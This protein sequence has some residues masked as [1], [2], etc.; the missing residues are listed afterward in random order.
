MIVNDK[1]AIVTGASSGIGEATAKALA[2]HGVKVVLASRSKEKLDNLSSQLKDSYVI[3]TDMMNEDEIKDM[4]KKAVDR[5]GRVDIL[6][7]NAGRGYDSLVENIEAPSYLELFKLNLLAPL[8][9]MQA[10]IPIMRR[11]SGGT[12]VNIS[13]GTSMMDIPNISAYSSLKRALNGLSLTAREELKKDKIVVSLVYPYMTET[14]FGK[15]VIGKPRDDSWLDEGNISKA[16]TP[17]YIAEKILE[18]IESEGAEIYAHDW[19]K[20][21]K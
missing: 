20:N 18:V 11:Q 5:F 10:V 3:Q 19:M 14:N 21:I 9:T 4:V 13:S 2:Q 15:N 1:V 7:N 12:I 6:V 17:E 16:D 8:I